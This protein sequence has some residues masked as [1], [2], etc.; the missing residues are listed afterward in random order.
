VG[1]NSA[2][3]TTPAVTETLNYWV[4]VTSNCAQPIVLESDTIT[5]TPTQ[6]TTVAITKQPAGKQIAS[7]GNATLTVEASGTSPLTYRWFEGSVNTDESKQVGNAATF[8]TPALT[9]SK[10]YWV[11]VTNACGTARSAVATITVGTTPPPCTPVTITSAPASG[12]VPLGSGVT[13]AVAATGTAPLAYQW[14]VGEMLDVSQP[15]TGATGESVALPAF[16]TP[17]TFKYWVRVTNTCGVANSNTITITVA[18]GSIATP[19]ISVP[20][21]GHVS[22]PYEVQWSGVPSQVSSSELQEATDPQFTKNLKTYQVTGA[23]KQVIDPH[24]E[25]TADTRFYYRVRSFNSCTGAATEYSR[26]TSIVITRPQPADS[27]EFSLS[28]PHTATQPFRQDYLVPGFGAN[29]TNSDTFSIAIVDA[30]WLTVFPRN[31][32]LSA[33][34]TTVQFTINPA[35]LTIGTTS[36]SVVVTRSQ[37]AS[38]GV[39]ANAVTTISLPFSV[40]KVTP[41]TPEPRS[42]TPPPGTLIIPAVAHADGIG[43]RFQSD[44]RIANTTDQEITYEISFTPSGT[45]G[46]ESGK[47]TSMVIAARETKSLDDIVK[48]WYGAGLLN[49]PGVGTLEIRPPADTPVNG[50]VA[51]SRT[52]AVTEKGTL[53][54]FIPALGLDKFIGSFAQDSLSKI[55]LQQI[56]NT[57]TYR[58]NVGFVEGAGEH[59]EFTARLLDGDNRELAT[60]TRSLPPYGHEQ[61][62]MSALFGNVPLQ[63]GRIEVL[64]TSAS[65]KATAYASVID[66]DTSDPLMIFPTQ[67]E[68]FSAQTFVV[69]GIAEVSSSFSNFHSDMRIYNASQSPV[70]INLNFYPLGNTNPQASTAPLTV[71][72]GQ[73]RALNDVLPSMFGVNSGAGSVTVNAPSNAPLV[74]TARTYSREADGGTYGQ[75]IP[76]V[77]AS[78]AT[79]TGERGIELLQLEQSNLYRT[80][81]GLIEVTGKPVMIEITAESPQNKTS[82]VT[83]FPMSGHEFRQGPMLADMG[84]STVFNGRI[85]IRVIGGEGRIAA[86]G[87][88]IDSRTSDPT[89]VPAQ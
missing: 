36:A 3:F 70:T 9:T 14:Y 15:I 23:M 83:T 37:G 22:T 17:G 52:Y 2:N 88:V 32:A 72:A 55:S 19:K 5:V 50:T 39:A 65:G 10:S 8:T 31:G 67:A 12:S 87:S 62:G 89:Y 44:V 68:R 58:T 64:V 6:C 42:A 85:T 40:S 66:N 7:G 53:G 59:V 54:Q 24:T 43:T 27:K 81:V 60:A 35:A 73:V 61:M 18:C 33:G 11:K 63:D 56:I 4:R 16:N 84:F 78:D 49:E 77:T 21:I 48:A 46:T 28:V 41:V 47:K 1:S 86:Y 25:I 34:G 26:T 38:K 29:A 82:A 30:P 75:F 76:G 45:N 79:G 69:P 13:F 80:N 20:A 57:P 51:S 74:V 71:G